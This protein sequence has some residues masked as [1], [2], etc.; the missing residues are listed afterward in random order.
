[1]ITIRRPYI[2][3]KGGLYYIHDLIHNPHTQKT[4]VSYQALYPPYAMYVE[5]IEMF[6]KEINPNDKDN[7]FNQ[8]CR[9]EIYTEKQNIQNMDMNGDTY[10]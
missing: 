5:P 9:F 2:H 1:M 3:F 7:I 8:N 6:L 10:K 4:S